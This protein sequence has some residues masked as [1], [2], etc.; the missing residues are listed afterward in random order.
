MFKLL[1]NRTGKEGSPLTTLDI[2]QKDHYL[3]FVFDAYESSLNSYS[4]QDNDLLYKGDVVE[5][6]LDSGDDFYYEFEVAPNGAKF[7]AKIKDGHAELIE[8]S[9]FEELSKI[10][11]SN[12]H[13]EMKFD[14]SKIKPLRYNAFRIET[15][16]VKQDY[17]LEAL[18]PT[19]SDTFHVKEKFLL[20]K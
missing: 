10:N 1:D 12:Y 19:L 18:S 7:S 20:I 2:Y 11:G 13:V 5:V 15:K 17:I 4:K 16:G 6:F 14:L 3:V 8:P 9:F